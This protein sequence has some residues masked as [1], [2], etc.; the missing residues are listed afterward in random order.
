MRRAGRILIP[1]GVAAAAVLAILVLARPTKGDVSSP[2]ESL[3]IILGSAPASENVEALVAPP[4]LPTLSST[5]PMP[6]ASAP[7]LRI[8]ARESGKA[9]REHHV[10]DAQVLEKYLAFHEALTSP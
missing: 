2:P 3:R 1:L 9:D 8:V 10:V 6:E 7:E 5:V 4:L